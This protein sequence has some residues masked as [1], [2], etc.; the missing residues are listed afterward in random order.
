MMNQFTV[1]YKQ[2]Y[3]QLRFSRKWQQ[4]KAKKRKNEI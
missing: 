1:V 4:T 3:M 2:V